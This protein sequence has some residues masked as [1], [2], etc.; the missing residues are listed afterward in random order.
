MTDLL[1]VIVVPLL[2]IAVGLCTI[3]LTLII[4]FAS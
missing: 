3:W 4:A 2:A 1:R